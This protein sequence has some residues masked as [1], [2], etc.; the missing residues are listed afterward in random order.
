[1]LKLLEKNK[2]SN[3]FM[4][5]EYLMEVLSM[6]N[7]CID[8]IDKYKL[9]TNKYIYNLSIPYTTKYDHFRGFIHY[10]KDNILSICRKYNINTYNY[11]KK[12]NNDQNILPYNDSYKSELSKYLPNREYS[13]SY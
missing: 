6:G 11:I 1:M 5:N 7:N 2:K 8:K 9:I 13:H 12:D 3:D 4:S 10:Y